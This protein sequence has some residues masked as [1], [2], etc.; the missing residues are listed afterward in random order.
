MPCTIK[1]LISSEME[2]P[3]CPAFSLAISREIAISPARPF[4]PL[5]GNDKTSVAASFP[6]NRLFKLFISLLLVT[7]TFTSPGTGTSQR[8]LL[9]NRPRE[10]ISVPASRVR[11]MIIAICRR[12]KQNIKRAARSP[13]YYFKPYPSLSTEVVGGLSFPT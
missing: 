11:E 7:R 8:T 1:I 12:T 6:K 13:P 2:C 10:V 3:N 5:D 4:N 9:T